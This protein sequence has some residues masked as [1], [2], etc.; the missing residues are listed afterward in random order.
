MLD[1]VKASSTD[2]NHIADEYGLSK[3]KVPLGGSQKISSKS[4]GLAWSLG[5]IFA[6]IGAIVGGVSGFFLGGLIGV[7]I[8]YIVN[9]NKK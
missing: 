6:I 1:S 5:I 3:C 8:G 9:E 7:V 2:L 4:S